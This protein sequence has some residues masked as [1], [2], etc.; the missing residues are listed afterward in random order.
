MV[1]SLNIANTPAKIGVSVIMITYKHESFIAEAIEGVLMQEC[2]FE[3]EL[4]IADDCSPDGTQEIVQKYIDEHPNGHWIKYHRHEKNIG[5]QEN[6]L[7]AASKANGEFIALCEGDDYWI[8]DEKLQTQVQV[9]LKNKNCQLVFTNCYKLFENKFQN[10]LKPLLSYTNDFDFELLG[11]LNQEYYTITPTAL[12]RNFN[13]KKLNKKNFMNSFLCDEYLFSFLLKNGGRVYFLN[14]HTANYRLHSNGANSLQPLI[15][16]L[17]YKLK[18][19]YLLKIELK[20][21][22]AALQVI[23]GVIK[24]HIDRLYNYT[25]DGFHGLSKWDVFKLIFR[26]KS[27]IILDYRFYYNWFIKKYIGK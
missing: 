10:D 15:K 12:Y 2:D 6:F 5:M 7:F 26:Y 17:F 20:N 3:V 8:D 4:I 25:F 27:T 22:K 19:L 13:L 23:N 18:T 1:S 24:R 21:K 11:Y 14:N 16:Q 9:I